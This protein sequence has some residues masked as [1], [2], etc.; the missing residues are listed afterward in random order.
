MSI[1]GRMSVDANPVGVIGAGSFGTA[2]AQLLSKN[3][4]VFLYS[5][6][7]E[8]VEH[9]NRTRRHQQITLSEHITASNDL[10]RIADQCNILFPIVPSDQFRSMMQS[11]APF[12][13]PF[14]ILIH[15]TKGFDCTSEYDLFQTETILSRRDVHTMSEVIRQE[16][17]VVRVGC[18]AGPNLS[19][20]I[21]DGQ[22]AATLV[23][24]PY[25]EVI[26]EGKRVLASALFH[27]F[28]SHDMLGAELAGALKNAIAIGA[29]LLGGLDLGKNLQA[30]LINR[31]LFEMIYLGNAMGA[32]TSSF[33]GTAGIGDLIATATSE[34]SRNYQFGKMLAA[35]RDYQSVQNSLPELAEGVRTIRIVKMLAKHYKVRVPIMETLYAIVFD[36]YSPFKAIDFLMKYPYDVDVDFL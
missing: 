20:E 3:T 18:L 8:V 35:N 21:L 26:S 28:G 22:P 1:F 15:G 14:H 4:K 13:R 11:V 17:N 31:G 10:A 23:A 5:R 19:R 6:Q 27:V 36:G 2:I 30:M 7:S 29:G 34:K 16:S 12:L 25:D 9:I 33:L 24:S 32:D